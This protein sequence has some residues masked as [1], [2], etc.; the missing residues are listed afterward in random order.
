MRSQGALE[1]LFGADGVPFWVLQ[2]EGEVSDDPVEGGEVGSDLIGIFPF[3]VG[4]GGLQL[5]VLGQ[6]DDQAEVLN[7]GLIDRSNRVVD[8][9]A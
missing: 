9:A 2:L 4:R 3:L 6:V 1:V 7:G 8:E 5:D